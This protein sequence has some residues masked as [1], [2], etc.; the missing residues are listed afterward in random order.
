MLGEKNP[1]DLLTKHFG[2]EVIGRHVDSLNMIWIE[3]RAESAPTLDSIESY[4]QTCVEDG[5]YFDESSD[6]G[7]CDADISEV[8]KEQKGER[9]KVRFAE[10]ITVRPI[11]AV[12]KGKATPARGASAVSAKWHSARSAEVGNIDRHVANER[13]EEQTSCIC[14]GQLRKGD[15]KQWSDAEGC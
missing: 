6:D 10:L 5:A 7:D 1:A 4:I 2:P 12:R 13:A 15:G 3:G 9:K 8:E 11:P 14:G